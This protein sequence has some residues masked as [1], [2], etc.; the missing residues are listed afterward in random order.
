MV[1]A[2]NGGEGCGEYTKS[3]YCVGVSVEGCFG[4]DAAALPDSNGGVLATGEDPAIAGDPTARGEGWRCGTGCEACHSAFVTAVREVALDVEVYERLW[5]LLRAG[6]E[7]AVACW[8]V[9]S[10]YRAVV[11]GRAYLGFRRTAAACEDYRADDVEMTAEGEADLE[12][13]SFVLDC[14]RRCFTCL[15]GTIL[16]SSP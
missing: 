6:R 2:E 10:F 16:T 9:P 4:V 14:I 1:A 12:L 5:K 13:C 15:D 7:R 8:D 11:A 3:P